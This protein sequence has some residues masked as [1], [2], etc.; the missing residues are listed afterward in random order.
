[1]VT[2]SNPVG[3]ANL[4]NNLHPVWRRSS[5]S[6]KLREW[7][8][9]RLSPIAN[10][11]RKGAANEAADPFFGEGRM[12]LR[13]KRMLEKRMFKLTQADRSGA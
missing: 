4:F 8:S 11:A 10:V 3:I 1:M 13:F 9:L 2:G 5:N 12:S 6:A 7:M